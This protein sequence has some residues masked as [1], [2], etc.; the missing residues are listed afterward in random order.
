M[1]SALLVNYGVHAIF[2]RAGNVVE[3]RYC[4]HFNAELGPKPGRDWCPKHRELV[5][6]TERCF[7]GFEREVGSDDA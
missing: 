1:P 3:C 7:A 5:C 2:T 4:R 6:P